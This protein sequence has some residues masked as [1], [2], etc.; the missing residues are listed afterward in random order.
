VLLLLTA[1]AGIWLGDVGFRSLDD[2]YLMSWLILLYR[3]E[4]I[5]PWALTC[6]G[7]WIVV[8]VE[9]VKFI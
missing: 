8:F 1:A 4:P 2:A 7:T 3:R 6:A 5:W 9:L